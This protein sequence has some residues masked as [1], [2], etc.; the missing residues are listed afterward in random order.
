M[1]SRRLSSCTALAVF[2]LLVSMSSNRAEGFGGLM[3]PGGLSVMKPPTAG[4][5]E[6]VHCVSTK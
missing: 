2:G 1:F 3:M 6:L 5:E 4:A